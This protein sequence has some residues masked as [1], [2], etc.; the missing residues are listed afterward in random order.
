M[1]RDEFNEKYKYDNSLKAF[2]KECSEEIVIRTY[3]DGSSHDERRLATKP[4]SEILF[5]IIY[6]ALIAY[7]YRS[8]DNGGSI[9]A[10]LDMAEFTCHE[11]L[12]EANAY[13]S[14]YTP[15]RKIT[16]TW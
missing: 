16:E 8:E 11:F 2:A 9:D 7:G 10:I 4:E 1:T 3:V 13:D 6:A 5:N 12:P 15:I 14:V